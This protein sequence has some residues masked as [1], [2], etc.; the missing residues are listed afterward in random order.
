MAKEPVGRLPTG[1]Q[2]GATTG[3]VKS[4]VEVKGAQLKLAATAATTNSGAFGVV[5]DAVEQADYG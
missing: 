3:N 2:A 4:N 5:A 1:R